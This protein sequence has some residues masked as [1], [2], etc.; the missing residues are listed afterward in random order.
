MK[1]TATRKRA[2]CIY[3]VPMLTRHPSLLIS[4]TL[5]LMLASLP[6]AQ[7]LAMSADTTGESMPASCEHRAPDSGLG[8]DFCNGDDCTG[9]HCNIGH[10]SCSVV[11]TAS[12]VA[13]PRGAEIPVIGN[14]LRS[15]FDSQ[16]AS[17]P[18][19]PPIA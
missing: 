10:N 19:R 3:C 14:R 12:L 18:Y 6:L 7:A 16:P 13:H 11:F 9:S 1:C 4:L 5:V 15:E 8:I 2:L 17:L